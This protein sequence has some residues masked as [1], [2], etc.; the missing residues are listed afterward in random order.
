MLAVMK[1]QAVIMN[2]DDDLKE[3][4]RPRIE[5]RIDNLEEIFRKRCWSTSRQVT[6]FFRQSTCPG[7]SLLCH[8]H[9]F[10]AITSF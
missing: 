8:I 6:S 5:Q 4:R 3:D 10:V 9:P 1:N 7:I 2:D